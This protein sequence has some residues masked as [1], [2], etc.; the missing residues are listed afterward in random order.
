[1]DFHRWTACPK[2]CV[3][4][5]LA[6]A[7]SLLAASGCG[8]DSGSKE[9]PTWVA[10]CG[11]VSVTEAEFQALCRQQSRRD[12]NLQ[13]T[14]EREREL[15]ENLVEKKLLLLEAEKLKLDQDPEFI[16]D[17]RELREQALM[18]RLF[19]QEG[20][21]LAKQ[22]KVTNDEI[23]RYYEQMRREVRFR[24][25]PVKPEEAQK[26]LG[27]WS[28]GKCEGAVESGPVSQAK[29]GDPWKKCLRGLQAKKSELVNIKGK[30]YLVELLEQKEVV[31]PPLDQV[32]EEIAGELLRRKKAALMQT[33][34]NSLKGNNPIKLNEA[35]FKH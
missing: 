3:V 32:R 10:R 30:P 28:A 12:P 11:Q 13:L 2:F 6:L 31:P 27:E 25:Q 16:Q 22:V 17:L 9:S 19:A 5:H 15:V 35:F 20:E 4:F 14:P 26:L 33:W 1:M 29:L 21:K 24:Y 18:K 34:V 8:A 23:Q 7:L